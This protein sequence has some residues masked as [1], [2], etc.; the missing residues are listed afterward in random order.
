MSGPGRKFKVRYE[1]HI[2]QANLLVEEADDGAISVFIHS[3][4]GVRY[5]PYHIYQAGQ[6]F[7]IHFRPISREDV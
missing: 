7:Q 4:E 1:E 6:D 2:G 5:L 3:Q